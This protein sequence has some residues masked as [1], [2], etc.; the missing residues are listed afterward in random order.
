M[1]QPKPHHLIPHALPTARARTENGLPN[2]Q[3]TVIY[4]LATDSRSAHTRTWNS[5]KPDSDHR[6]TDLPRTIN[7]RNHAIPIHHQPPTLSPTTFQRTDT[8]EGN[9]HKKDWPT[10]LASF[11]PHLHPALHPLFFRPRPKPSA[12][13]GS[14]NCPKTITPPAAT[15]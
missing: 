11:P 8:T 5:L 3:E 14:V 13:T 10:S 1:A 9:A 2:G 6:A 15:F 7:P 4:G 12:K